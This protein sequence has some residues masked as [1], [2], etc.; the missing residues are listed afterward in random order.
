MADLQIP[1]IAITGFERLHG[2]R[3]TL[4]DISGSITPFVKPERFSHVHPL[5]LA[6]KVHHSQN[7]VNFGIH[8]LHNNLSKYTNG[9]VQVCFAGLVEVALP[10][11]HDRALEW[12]LFAGPWMP[13]KNLVT[14]VRDA[15]PRLT[16]RVWSSDVPLPPA[17][18]DERAALM[19]EGLR[20]L[21]ARLL[22]W[23][24]ELQRGALTARDMRPSRREISGLDARR[25]FIMRYILQNHQRPI[26]LADLAKAL[27]LSKTR[28]GHVVSQTC[29]E[30][31]AALLLDARMRTASGM[32]RH[33]SLPIS[34]VVTR[35]GFSDVSH[36]HKYFKAKFGISP[37]QYRKQP[38]T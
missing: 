37:L 23:R 24:Q 34:E 8:E 18:D 5:C 9:R 30:T 31:F 1:E 13:G 2:V 6:V 14:A 3:V 4:H 26:Q 19:L 12:V 10:V 22:T 27:H 21:A 32:L 38:R 15:Q 7:C 20:Q 28:C 29:G 36:F 33:T 11:F 25:V 17:I 35:S 16:R